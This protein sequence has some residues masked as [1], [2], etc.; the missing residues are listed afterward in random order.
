MGRLCAPVLSHRVMPDA[1]VPVRML[2][3]VVYPLLHEYVYIV[4]TEDTADKTATAV[5]G[6]HSNQNLIWCVKIRAYIAFR[7]Y[8]GF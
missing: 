6:E 4:C 2:L 7:V 1:L 8:H 3:P 5:Y